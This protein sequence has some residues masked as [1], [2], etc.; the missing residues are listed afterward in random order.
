[1]AK[2]F[3]GQ[4]Y[5]A[6]TNGKG[7]HQQ[8]KGNR[9][10]ARVT[11]TFSTIITA[12]SVFIVAFCLIFQMCP[13]HGTSMMTTLNATGEDTNKAL[14]CMLGEPNYSDIIVMKLYIQNMQCA[15]Y[16]AAAQGDT[17]ALA[18]LHCSQQY[19]QNI[20]N[21]LK[22]LEYTESDRNGNYKL[23]V[24][25]LIAK[26]GDRISMRRVGSNYYIYLNGEKLEE[27]YLDPAVASHDAL[28]FERMWQILNNTAT[29][30]MTIDWVTTDYQKLLKDNQYKADDG[31]GTPS[32]FM[33]TVPDYY[34]FVM[35]DNRGGADDKYNH[36]WDST[37]FGPL[38]L[39]N[40]YS[41]CVE[42]LS[43]NIS[44]PEYL[45]NKF[46]YYVCFGWA[47]QK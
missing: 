46:V 14:T 22:K 10:F 16:L 37:Y 33:L 25:R 23:I 36:S 38:P 3:V 27:D 19:A 30:S 18:S 12:V 26:G 45:W 43:N 11:V 20:I 47:W 4:E 17:T 13:V 42:V 34:Y 40:Y 8:S 28:N 21:N 15:E 39:E 7:L 9:V 32:D 44:M 24:K 1:M 2:K 31:D 41:C 35:G 29:P 6:A 5:M